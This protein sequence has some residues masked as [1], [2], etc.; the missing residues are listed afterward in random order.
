MNRNV[1]PVPWKC[2]ENLGAS[3]RKAPKTA[4]GRSLMMRTTG[5]STLASFRIN[6]FRAKPS[7]LVE[8]FNTQSWPSVRGGNSL[9]GGKS[10]FLFLKGLVFLIIRSCNTVLIM[11]ICELGKVTFHSIKFFFFWQSTLSLENFNSSLKILI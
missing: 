11:I 6:E 10:L 8:N 9:M 2:S 7:L 5:P 3:D 4:P 1:S